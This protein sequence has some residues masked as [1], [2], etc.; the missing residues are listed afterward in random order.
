LRAWFDDRIKRDIMKSLFRPAIALFIGLTLITGVAYPLL[1]TA[2]GKAMFPRQIEGTLIERDGRIVGSALIGQN[3]S[4][5]EYFWGRPSATSPYPNNAAA[6]AG[7]NLGPLNPALIDAVKNRISALQ[8][9]DPANNLPVPID[10]VTA[11]A[12]GLDPE[13]SPAAARYQANRVTRARNL[14]PARISELIARH[15]EDRQLAFLGESRVN[16]LKL[17]LALDALR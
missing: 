10:L 17:N 7:S 5:P 4:E 6:S 14:P 15:T 11:S 2:I 8:Q 3:F 16:V 1:A 12:S 9:A 13:I